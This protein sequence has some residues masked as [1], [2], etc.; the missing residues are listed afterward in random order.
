M[1]VAALIWWVFAALAFGGAVGMVAGRNPVA[2]LLSLVLTLFSLGVLFILMGAH[3][4]GVI[5]VIV[6][7]G[8]IMVL[9][10]Y[11]IMLLNL[12]H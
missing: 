1:T 9:F 2:S 4:I 11:V 6:Y 12:G 8:A 10:L 5:Q 3:F 7:A